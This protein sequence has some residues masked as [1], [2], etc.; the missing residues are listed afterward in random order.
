MSQIKM[1]RW[2][3]PPGAS[4]SNSLELGTDTLLGIYTPPAMD[5]TQLKVQASADG[6]AFVDILDIGAPLIVTA[7]AEAYL[8]LDPLKSMG[9]RHIRLAHLDSTGSAVTES[10][11]RTFAPVFRSFQ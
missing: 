9:A 3:T 5:A 7:E 11:E 1:G 8:A 10:E 2:I 4:T 6:V